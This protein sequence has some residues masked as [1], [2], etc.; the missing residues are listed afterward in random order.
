[1][2]L[3]NL[4]YEALANILP[5]LSVAGRSNADFVDLIYGIHPELGAVTV[6]VDASSQILL[7]S[8]FTYSELKEQTHETQS[9]T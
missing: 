4:P 3:A 1:M 2:H 5:G 6:R 8:T 7:A 9:S